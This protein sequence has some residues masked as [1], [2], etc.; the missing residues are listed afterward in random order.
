MYCSSEM[1]SKYGTE[2]WT[3]DAEMS[4]MMPIMARRPLLISAVRELSL[5]SSDLP[6]MYLRRRSVTSLA[7]R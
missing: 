2:P 4:D 7:Q 6:E 5:A 3:V 1:P